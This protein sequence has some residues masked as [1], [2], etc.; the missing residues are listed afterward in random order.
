MVK[1]KK[2]GKMVVG[3]VL[4]LGPHLPSVIG[5]G[6]IF[7]DG[8]YDHLNALIER[9]PAFGEMFVPIANV[10]P[11]LRELNFDYSHQMKGQGRYPTLYREVQQWFA[12]QTPTQKP[13]TP[14]GVTTE[15]Y[16]A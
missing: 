16:H 3:Q 1:T 9:C 7:R 13:T 11:V 8:I 6:T 4:Y 14:S 12:K 15:E 2:Q 5:Y 10:G